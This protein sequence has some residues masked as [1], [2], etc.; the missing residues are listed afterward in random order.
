MDVDIEHKEYEIRKE[1]NIENIDVDIS[2]LETSL[3]ESSTKAKKLFMNIKKL[4]SCHEYSYTGISDEDLDYIID[5]MQSMNQ[6]YR[7]K[8]QELSKLFSII[9]KYMESTKHTN[10]KKDIYKANIKNVLD[11]LKTNI[12]TIKNYESNKSDIKT[13]SIGHLYNYQIDQIHQLKKDIQQDYENDKDCKEIRQVRTLIEQYYQVICEK[14]DYY[15]KE[16]RKTN[17]TSKDYSEI[18]N[19]VYEYRL[20]YKRLILYIKHYKIINKEKIIMCQDGS[21]NL[22]HLYKYLDKLEKCLEYR[23]QNIYNFIETAK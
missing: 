23:I 2:R 10:Y 19:K 6:N 1:I 17:E 20:L 16:L 15:T 8:I 9:R 5:R 14:L 4:K 21:G 12:T 13:Q 7:L 11:L 18:L 3:R 22:T